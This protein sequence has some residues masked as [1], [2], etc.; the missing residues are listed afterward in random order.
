[1]RTASPKIV[2]ASV[3]KDE[4]TG[5]PVSFWWPNIEVQPTSCPL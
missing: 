1:M 4:G 2:V 5:P 3:G